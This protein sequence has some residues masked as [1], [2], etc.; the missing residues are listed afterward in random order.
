MRG[1]RV[2]SS[3]ANMSRMR[4]SCPCHSL[5]PGRSSRHGR[6]AFELL[7]LFGLTTAPVSRPIHASSLLGVTRVSRS[8][9]LC[10]SRPR[11]LGSSSKE[12]W[13]CA[14]RVITRCREERTAARMRAPDGRPC[15][16]T[17]ALARGGRGRARQGTPPICERRRNRR[18][19]S[20]RPAPVQGRPQQGPGATTRRRIRHQSRAR[21][22]DRRPPSTHCFRGA[23]RALQIGGGVR[24]LSRSTC[25]GRRR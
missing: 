25:L 4:R 17:D 18:A 7:N 24:W 20:A 13:R 16:S 15:S 8:T 6:Y 2:Q 21:D 12:V 5:R 11:G 1:T 10:R 9:S 23:A 14:G 19:V 22:E 3:N